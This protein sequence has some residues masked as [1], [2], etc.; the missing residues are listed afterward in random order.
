M[1]EQ[2]ILL[3]FV[4]P[5]AGITILLPFWKSKKEIDYKK[6]ERWQLIQNK[7]NNTANY[8]NYIL[9]IL[10]IFIGQTISINSDINITFTL[11]RLCTYGVCF[12]GLRNAIELF[13]LKYFDNKI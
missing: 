6:D 7:A 9:L 3:L 5:S 13:A 8:L 1:N 11:N 2:I 10:F 12:I 4:I